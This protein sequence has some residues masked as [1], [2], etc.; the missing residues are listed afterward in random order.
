MKLVLKSVQ[1]RQ[2]VD[3]VLQSWKLFGRAPLA[4]TGLFGTFLFVAL[5]ALF[6]PL[7]GSL[8]VVASL[9]LLSLVMM[10]GSA[11][12]QRGQL[13]PPSLL[14]APLKAEPLRRNRLFIMGAAYAVCTLLVLLI[15]DGLDGGKFNEL[16]QVMATGLETEAQRQQAQ[17]LLADE[18]LRTAILIRLVLTGL[19]SV[20]F[21][22][23]PALV[24][25]GG[26][27]VAQALFSSVLALW[28]SKLAFV[29]YLLAWFGLVA[30]GGAGLGV[31]L[32]TLGA[33]HLL[34]VLAMPMGLTVSV[35][36]YIS[37]YFMFVQ[38][39]GT[40]EAQGD[41]G[42]ETTAAASEGEPPLNPPA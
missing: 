40:T 34:G 39:F 13:V 42:K 4:L 35:V 22:Y 36:F 30:L 5:I 17:T 27:G 10:M 11:A 24:W 32:Q 33:G 1:P 25:W 19:M 37:L 29:L 23:A 7:L 9:P 2:G 20:P 15:S 3:W 6:I 21:W 18:D 28:R 26:Q 8:L 38:T 16:Q 31:L 14:L 41:D 12:A